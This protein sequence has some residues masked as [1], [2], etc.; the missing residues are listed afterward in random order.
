[1]NDCI[2]FRL[3]RESSHSGQS[4]MT[5]V[6]S[7]TLTQAARRADRNTVLTLGLCALVATLVQTLVMPVIGQVPELLNTTVL[8][9]SWLITAML[10]SATLTTV[11]AGRLAD[12]HGTRPVIL[13]CLALLFAGS[14]LGAAAPS[15]EVLI[16]ARTL[17]GA[18]M[19]TVP[20][21]LAAARRAAPDGE[22]GAALGTISTMVGVGGAVGY[23]F[24]AALTQYL[25]WRALFVVS[26]VLATTT[27][28]LM[29]RHLPAVPDVDRPERAARTLFDVPGALGLTLALGAALIAVS[30]APAW[31]W[32][33]P[34]VL[35]L[36]ALTAAILALWVRH[37]RR[38]A[39]PLV[40]LGL[41]MRR[42]VL[43]ANGTTAFLGFSMYVGMVCVPQLLQAEAGD[44]AGFGVDV[45][46]SG[47]VLLPAGVAAT[48][49]P[50][51][52]TTLTKRFG[53]RVTLAVSALLQLTGY[54][55]LILWH[56]QIWQVILATMATN[57][58]FQMAY[59]ASPTVIMDAVPADRLSGSNSLNALTRTLGTTMS[60]AVVG[61]VLAASAVSAGGA[62]SARGFTAVFTIACVASVAAF[63]CA[64]ALPRAPRPKTRG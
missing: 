22:A 51:L 13:G 31:G 40:D 29:L 47:L 49:V 14:V 48:F 15:I 52:G 6:T 25:G 38:T 5:I 54:G 12:I 11:V 21:C 44:G 55:V 43:L 1:M 53:A 19:A 27:F 3:V 26:A 59:A 64:A 23:T 46:T 63:C 35:G 50:R 41:A 62:P 2:H 28:A 8:A 17:Q 33:S 10:V 56:G 42:P 37:E 16:A 7:A 58:A 57:A 60:S 36:L 45:M 20:L 34:R 9:A 39:H 30:R 24:C 32:T 18:A 4:Q 61:T